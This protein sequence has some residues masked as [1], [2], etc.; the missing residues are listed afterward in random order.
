MRRR[1]LLAL[2][3]LP[4]ATAGCM[5]SPTPEPAAATAPAAEPDQT[6]RTLD[7]FCGQSGMTVSGD[8]VAAA[9]GGVALQVSGDAPPEAEWYLHLSW[10]GGWGWGQHAPL[11]SYT[12]TEQV[13]PGELTL[14][15]GNQAGNAEPLTV[16]VVD[17]DALW[18]PDTLDDV[19][20]PM[21][22][23]PSWAVGPGVGPS[24]RAAVEDLIA[25]MAAETG[26]DLSVY[27]EAAPAP[28][29]YAGGDETWIIARD[30][31][32]DVVVQVRDEGAAWTASPD[33]FCG[34]D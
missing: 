32:P 6:P 17:P 29:E 15:C 22:A 34:R 19:G 26:Q 8:V 10:G 1:A 21:G 13:P 20:C 14:T 18:S 4:I 9:P 28:I 31:E 30:G 5:S 2:L 7:V 25:L 11:D 23:I 24:A 33:Y 3:A 12:W 27:E 16:L